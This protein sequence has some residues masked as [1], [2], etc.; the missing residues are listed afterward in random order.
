MLRLTKER[1][2]L[3]LLALVALVAA[4]LSA[5]NLPKEFWYDEAMTLRLFVSQGV[6]GAFTDYRAPNNHLV[7]TSLLAAWMRLGS[8][9]DLPL[10]YVRV[11][12]WLFSIASVVVLFLAVRSWRGTGAAAWA[13][14]LMGTS[15][16]FLSFSCQVRGYSLSA[17]WCAIGLFLVFRI[18]SRPSFLS[19]VTY[20]RTAL[21][22][23]GTIP[24]NL[25]VF[26]ALGLWAVIE[27]WRSGKLRERTG[28]TAAAV[29]LVSPPAGILWYLWHPGVRADFWHHASAAAP[30]LGSAARFLAELG[31]AVFVDLL[32]LLPFVA[33]GIYF[34]VR[35]SEKEGLAPGDEI[36]CQTGLAAAPKSGPD[37]GTRKR[38]I[39]L[40][41]V[42][43]L[44]P[45]T[46]I[47]LKPLF[48][49]NLFPLLPWWFA[50]L[51]ILADSAMAGLRARRPNLQWLSPAALGLVV[52][53]SCYREATFDRHYREQSM[54]LHPQGPYY[55]YY[56]VDYHPTAVIEFLKRQAAAEG[57]VAFVDS[58]DPYSMKF[59]SL[60]LGYETL[61]RMGTRVRRRHT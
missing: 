5:M 55:Q 47:G 19:L 27:L 53:F 10:W 39:A 8:L 50:S 9:A 15:H 38:G 41:A 61:Y 32:W 12:P 51:G 3:V 59:H 16:F 28:F 46:A 58:S 25:L 1:Q 4:G 34:R 48:P 30:G 33:L 22:A 7:F 37:H 24:T 49:R 44:L 57:A 54:G 2:T 26:M 13:A 6:L 21:A 29:F 20:A 60:L 35:A 18:P 52:A 43:S 45:L 14:V 17:L 11:L 31:H 42:C 40:F 23:V 56:Q 36:G